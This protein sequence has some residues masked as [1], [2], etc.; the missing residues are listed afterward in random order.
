MEF[1]YETWTAIFAVIWIICFVLRKDLRRKMIYSSIFAG[2][3]GLSEPLYTGSFWVPQFK[4]LALIPGEL[5]LFDLV[6]CFLIGGFAAVL[7]QVISKKK[8]FKTNVNPLLVFVA[9]VVFLAKFIFDLNTMNW[10]IISMLVGAIVIL[11]FLDRE[12]QKSVFFNAILVAIVYFCILFVLWQIFPALGQS[13]LFENHIGLRILAIPIEEPL[14]AFS[15]ALY[16]SPLYDIINSYKR[17]R[18]T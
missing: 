14:F 10:S 7:Y 3:L 18:K 12:Q 13:Y 16:W 9:P 2:I 5:Y 1:I 11:I 4:T 15:F 6:W 17:K 8:V